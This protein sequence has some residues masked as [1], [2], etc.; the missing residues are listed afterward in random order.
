MYCIWGWG[1][2]PVGRTGLPGG[3]WPRAARSSDGCRTQRRSSLDPTASPPGVCPET[4]TLRS[5]RTVYC[6]KSHARTRTHTLLFTHLEIYDYE[7]VQTHRS[8]SCGHDA[9]GITNGETKCQALRWKYNIWKFCKCG[10]SLDTRMI[11]KRLWAC[12]D[13]HAS[14]ARH[15]SAERNLSLDWFKRSRQ[16]GHVPWQ[17]IM[18]NVRQ[19]TRQF[20]PIMGWRY[21]EHALWV[22]E[23]DTRSRRKVI[24]VKYSNTYKSYKYQEI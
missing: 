3:R 16:K 19:R 5:Q 21:E 18:Y 1:A 22:H 8:N 10:E 13:P 20:Y 2:A 17:P 23:T 11:R 24:I 7:T 6:S 12:N 9:F 14:P 4:R 15:G